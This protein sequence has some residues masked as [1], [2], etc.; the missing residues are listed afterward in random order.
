M[1]R[2]VTIYALYLLAATSSVHGLAPN[3]QELQG[4][5]AFFQGVV[6]SAAVATAFIGSTSPAVATTAR[7]GEASPW[8]GYYDDP[9]HP[10]CLRQ[11]KVVGAP[12]R[13][14]GTPSPFP[15]VEVR[16]YDGPEGATMCTDAPETRASVWTVKGD[17]KNGKAILDFSSKGGPTNLVAKFEDG[18][19]VFPDGNKWTKVPGVGTPD[20]L[21]KE[22]KTLKSN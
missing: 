22:M 1:I 4:R 13:P 14:N 2:S 20:R 12:M 21:P 8:T 18:G 3:Q 5:R 17:L 19:I 16:G 7:T 11:V 9:N 6:S 15:V 10:G